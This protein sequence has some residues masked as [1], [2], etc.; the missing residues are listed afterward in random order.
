MK[1]RLLPFFCMGMLTLC[2]QTDSTMIQY[3][4]RLLTLLTQLRASVDDETK[5]AE[6]KKLK[7]E[8]LRVLKMPASYLYPFEKLTTIGFVPSPD[9]KFR[10]VNWN[11][12]MTDLSQEYVCFLQHFDYRKKTQIVTEFLD[13]SNVL[14]PKTDDVL[15]A[16]KWY[17]A[18]YY[19]VIPV[20]KSGKTVYTLLAWD[21]NNAMSTVKIIDAMVFQG[22]MPKL[23]VSFFKDK[24]STKKRV[25]F[26]YSKKAT[27]NLNFE[28]QY[29]RISF[30]HLAPETPALE[31]FYSFYVPDFSYDSYVYQSNKWVLHEDIIATNPPP[32]KKIVMFVKNSKTGEFEAKKVKNKWVN[33]QDD[34]APISG[35]PH[36]AITPENDPRNPVASK[37][38]ESIAPAEVKKEQKIGLSTTLGKRKPKK[39]KGSS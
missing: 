32:P 23:G 17:G 14:P 21:G 15:D 26:E 33:P 7:S 9:G 34:S 29:N 12:E 38:I 10:F 11:V 28:P 4:D 2:A 19:R 16:N 22:N 24:A 20:Q 36:V 13:K 25:Y 37:N 39:R 6:N 3:E 18:L 35:M 8:M 30:D 27:M 5:I 1:R 31:G